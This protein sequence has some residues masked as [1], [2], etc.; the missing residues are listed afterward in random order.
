MRIAHVITGTNT[1]GAERMLHKLSVAL[2]ARGHEQLVVS[3][4]PTGPVGR[5]M[6][7]DGIE[8][9][10]LNARRGA[11]QPGRLLATARLLNL[12]APN[13][14]QSWMYHADLLCTLARPMLRPKPVHLWN[15]RGST[16]NFDDYGRSTRRVVKL[17]ARLSKIP[18]AV[19]VNSEAG[20]KDHELFGYN[21]R[22]WQVLPNGFDTLRFCPDAAA[23]RRLRA[24]FGLELDSRLVAVVARAHPMKDHR[25]FLA[26]L[27]QL[28][29]KHP[30]L[31]ALLI[32]PGISA[33]T[34]LIREALAATGTKNQITLVGPRED[35]DKI[36]PGMDL[37]CLPSASGEGF[38]N[39]VGEAMACGVP[40]VVTEVGDSA[41]IVESTGIAVAPKDPTALATAMAM[42]L[43][44]APK[45]HR[46]R[47]VACRKQIEENYTIEA[48]TDRYETLYTQ[49][50]EEGV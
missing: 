46:A 25:N 49:L 38:P 16:R 12:F 15:V 31:H 22:R 39:V 18:S 13:I 21:P 3:M 41:L 7:A 32:G 20:R 14:L 6:L 8:V 37:L 36:L 10:S 27:A 28:T 1:G 45:E 42:L 40:C 34:P 47:S 26:A 24:Q 35:I 2:A 9:R 5:A 4:I 50:L 29:P 17:C 19:I 11:L 23:A 30:K 43:D 33:D 44:E 48:I